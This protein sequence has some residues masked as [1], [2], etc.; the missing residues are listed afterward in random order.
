MAGQKN[1][2]GKRNYLKIMGNANG[3]IGARSG[4][5]RIRSF[6]VSRIQILNFQDRIRGSGSSANEHGFFVHKQAL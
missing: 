2:K 5:G 1:K 3:W 4:S 6:W